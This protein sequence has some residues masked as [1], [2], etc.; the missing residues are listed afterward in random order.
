MSHGNDSSTPVMTVAAGG[1]HRRPEIN[2]TFET[3]DQT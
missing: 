2:F 3:F 1:V